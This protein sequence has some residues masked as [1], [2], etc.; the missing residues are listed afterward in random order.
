MSKMPSMPLFVSDYDGDTAHLSFE[1]DGCYLRL[2]R[3]CWKTPGCS[4]PDDS[5]WIKRMM[6]STDEEFE[7]LIEPVIEEFFKKQNGRV[8][9]PRLQKEFQ[10]V[11]EVSKKRKQAAKQGVA[12][13]RLKTKQKTSSKG[14]VLLEPNV[15]QTLQQNATKRSAPTP[16]PTPSKQATESE[17]TRE[18][19][20][21]VQVGLRLLRIMGVQDN[22]NF[23]GNFG[24]IDQ[25][26][27]DGADPEK[28]IFPTVE[29]IME[30]RLG[31]PPNSLSYFTKAV[32]EEKNNRT[33]NVSHETPQA[34]ERDPK[35]WVGR[36]NVWS[37]DGRW[38]DHWGPKPGEEGCR[39]P[40]EI[41]NKVVSIDNRRTA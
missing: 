34:N 21:R 3:L 27:R 39:C 33:R 25:W 8:F 28:D 40:D 12:A 15:K 37:G 2:L 7:R 13:K 14:S 4:V 30:R 19:T 29:S 6:R 32:M 23:M 5:I 36:L 31:D 24:V 20:P 10:Y 41:L 16:T 11:S 35:I 1:E 22:P 17:V 9:H 38:P 18:R 26:L